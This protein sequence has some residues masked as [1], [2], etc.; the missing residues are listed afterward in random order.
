MKFFK[1]SLYSEIF[2]EWTEVHD[3]HP[4][5]KLDT[6]M[7]K[8]IEMKIFVKNISSIFRTTQCQRRSVAKKCAVVI[9]KI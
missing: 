2:V 7:T 8:E 1:L 9:A 3:D 4:S 5:V 6:E